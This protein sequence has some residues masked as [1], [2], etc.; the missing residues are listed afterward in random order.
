MRFQ[1]FAATA[2]VAALACSSTPPAPPGAVT[3]HKDVEP[4]LQKSC[5]MC[6]QPGG[7]APFSM[8][9]YADAK[10]Y[11]ASMVVKTQDKTMPPW[12]AQSTSECAPR[13][14]WKHD[15]RLSDQEIATI[16]AWHDGGDWE[17]NPSDA[18]PPI[19]SGS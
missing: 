3:F 13:F 6:H 8:L 7:I 16:K 12:G 19:T 17:G 9:T 15:V 1:L 11:A 10:P 14:T 4:I 18:P 2:C 5:Q